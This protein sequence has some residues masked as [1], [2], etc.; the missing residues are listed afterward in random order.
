MPVKV[1][2]PDPIVFRFVRGG[3]LIISKWGLEAEDESLIIPEMN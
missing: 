3:V 2:N 1:I